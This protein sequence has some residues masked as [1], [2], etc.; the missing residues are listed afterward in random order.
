[1]FQ[2]GA[3]WSHYLHLIKL[4]PDL[5][6]LSKFHSQGASV[7]QFELHSSDFLCYENFSPKLLQIY[8]NE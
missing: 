4:F 7:K 5:T 1:M 3:G 8:A 6:K 2:K